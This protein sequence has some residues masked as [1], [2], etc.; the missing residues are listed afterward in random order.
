MSLETVCNLSEGVQ[1]RQEKFGLLFYDYHGPRLYFLPTKDLIKDHFFEGKQT[2]SKLIE[3]ICAKHQ[4]WSRQV[5]Q[6]WVNR[7][8]ERL[9]G[10]GLIYEQSVC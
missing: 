9:E 10:K 5:I 1:V 8:L 3:S 6:E 4:D 2:V 7:I